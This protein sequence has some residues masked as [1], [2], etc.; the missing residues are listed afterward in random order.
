MVCVSA[1]DYGRVKLIDFLMVIRVLKL[2]RLIGSIKRSVRV[3][4]LP[5]L[6]NC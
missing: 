2:I 6:S 1:V 5:L 3:V 4:S